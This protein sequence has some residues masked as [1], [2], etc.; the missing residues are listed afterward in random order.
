M[1]NSNNISNTNTL[2][3]VKCMNKYYRNYKLNPK[4]DKKCIHLYQKYIKCKTKCY[5]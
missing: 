3:W 1:L 2:N 4:K 5:M